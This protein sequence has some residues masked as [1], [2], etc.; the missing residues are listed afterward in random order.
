[1]Q[2]QQQQQQT[3]LEETSRRRLDSA[4]GI[5]K[6]IGKLGELFSRFSSLVAQ[7]AEVVERLDDDVEGAVFEVEAG[8]ARPPRPRRTGLAALGMSTHARPPPRDRRAARECRR[9][10]RR[11]QRRR[12]SLKGTDPS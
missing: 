2:Q 12:R 8:H 11:S 7:Q 6:E 3:M 5:E 1:M 10:R 9:R 4:H